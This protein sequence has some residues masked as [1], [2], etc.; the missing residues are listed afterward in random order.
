MQDS[1]RLVADA[2]AMDLTVVMPISND[3]LSHSKKVRQPEAAA[4]EPV[5][6]A[7]GTWKS[8]CYCGADVEAMRTALR[9]IAEI[10]TGCHP[11]DCPERQRLAAAQI[12][13]S[14]TRRSEQ[15]QPDS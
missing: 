3:V 7:C 11:H 14:V 12:P 1:I 5:C 9:R 4:N 6:G 10:H 15:G 13:V 8:C 2:T